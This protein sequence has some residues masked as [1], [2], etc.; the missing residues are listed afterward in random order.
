MV[1]SVDASLGNPFSYCFLPS[2]KTSSE[3]FPRLKVIVPPSLP[4][5]SSYIKGSINQNWIYSTFERS[6]SVVVNGLIIPPKLDA[7]FGSSS[8]PFIAGL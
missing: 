1:L 6:K 3:I 8:V 5:V 7:G 4:A 2:F